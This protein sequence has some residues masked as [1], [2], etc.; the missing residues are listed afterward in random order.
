[1]DVDFSAAGVKIVFFTGANI[2]FSLHSANTMLPRLHSNA[3]GKVSFTAIIGPD[4]KPSMTKNT[5]KGAS[6]AINIAPSESPSQLLVPR[7]Y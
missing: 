4:Y 6:R 3:L 7:Q 1:M 5:A 2:A